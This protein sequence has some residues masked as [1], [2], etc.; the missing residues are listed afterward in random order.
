MIKFYEW[1]CKMKCINR[2][3]VNAV[4]IATKLQ[5]TVTMSSSYTCT[6]VFGALLIP[7]IDYNMVIAIQS[8]TTYTHMHYQ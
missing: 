2:D 7:I 4:T 5:Q 1:C 8:V 6:C 3:W